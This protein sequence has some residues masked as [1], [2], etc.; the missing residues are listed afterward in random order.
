[1][2]FVMKRVF[3]LRGE[4]VAVFESLSDARAMPGSAEKITGVRRASVRAAEGCASF[5]DYV[6]RLSGKHTQERV[7]NCADS[8]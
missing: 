7:R 2:G 6:A 4:V 3:E 1:M 5:R 8:V